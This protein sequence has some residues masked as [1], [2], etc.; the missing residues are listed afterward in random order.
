MHKL[1]SY[2][3]E[4]QID[5]EA[6]PVGH[7]VLALDANDIGNAEGL[8]LQKKRESNGL[9]VLSVAKMSPSCNCKQCPH[10]TTLTTSWAHS[11]DQPSFGSSAVKYDI[12][13]FVAL[14][15]SG[16]N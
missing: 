7:V 4:M 13:Q 5:P 12:I 15:N 10:Y 2:L 9:V 14:H 1:L 16:N 11:V 3:R 8:N 6:S